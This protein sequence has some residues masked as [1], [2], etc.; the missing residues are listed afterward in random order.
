MALG[1]LLPP[2]AGAAASEPPQCHEFGRTAVEPT[3]APRAEVRWTCSDRASQPLGAAAA[4][5]SAAAADEPPACF[6]SLPGPPPGTDGRWTVEAG[7]VSTGSVW[8]S[9]P[10]SADLAFSVLDQPDHGHVGSLQKLGGQGATF[11]YTADAGHRGPDAFTIRVGDGANTTDTLVLVTVVEPVNDPPTCFGSILAGPPGPGGPYAVEAG[12]PARG[13]VS[14]SDD[15]R[16]NLSFSIL[17]G[18]DHGTL[19]PPQAGPLIDM[20]QSATFTYTAAADYRGPDAFTFRVSDGTHSVD[21]TVEVVVGD[22]VDTPPSCG[23]SLNGIV[24]AGGRFAVEDGDTAAGSIG[25]LDDGNADLTFTVV[26]GPDHGTMSPLQEQQPFPG[27]T[28]Q[29]A[30]YTYKPVAG[31]RGP[32]ALTLRV[33]DGATSTDTVVLISVVEPVDDPPV[34]SATLSNTG[35]LLG[36]RLPA[37]AGEP[38]PGTLYCT[39]DEGD[40]LTFSIADGP[41]HGTLSPLQELPLGLG[42]A[43]S[44]TYTPTAAHRGEDEFTVRA[45]DGTHQVQTVLA[46]TVVEPVNDAPQCSV[47]LFPSVPGPAGPYV[48]EAGEVQSGSVLCTDDEGANLAFSVHD[49]PDHGTLGPLQTFPP[50]TG[51]QQA[52]FTYTPDLAYRGADE[53]T[54]RVTDGQNT[55]DRKLDV[56]VVEP[57]NQP[58]QC[59]VPGTITLEQGEKLSFGPWTACTD[60]DGDTLTLQITDQ[61]DHG[62]ITG[63]DEDGLFT[64]T[65][66]PSPYTGPDSFGVSVSDGVN[67][68]SANVSIQV[69]EFVNDTP[70]C[71]DDFVDVRQP[72]SVVI[73]P[74]CF[75]DEE[76][77]LSYAVSRA[78]EHG[79]LTGDPAGGGWTYTPDPGYTG[80]DS[81][82]YRAN[83]GTTDS[84]G[85][86]VHINVLPAHRIVLTPAEDTPEVGSSHAVTA[87]VRDGSG[88]AQAGKHVRW[89]IAGA[90]AEITGGGLT[91]AFGQVEI[92]W[93]RS[94]AGNDEL[95]AYVD[96]DGDGVQDPGE[97]DALARAHWRAQSDV[98][99]PDA[100]TPTT[101]TGAPLPTVDVGEIVNPADPGERYFTVS[102]S[103]T[104]AAGVGQCPGVADGRALKLP[105]SVVIDPGAGAVQAGSVELFQ[106]AAGAGGSPL[107]PPGVMEPTASTGGK[108]TF[109]LDCI[110]TGDLYLRYTL[111]EG[112][113]SATYTVPIGGIVLIDPQ[114][115]V[116][117]A[118]AYDA[119]IAAGDTPEQAR[120]AAAIEG[121]TVTLQRKVGDDFVTVLS[122]D[123]GITPHVNPQTIGADGRYQWDV[124][125]GV[126]RVIVT[127]DGYATATSDAVTIPPPVLDLH[128]A[129]EPVSVPDT[130]APET[131][132]TD[133]PSG[134]TSDDTPTFAFSS[135][136]AGSSFECRVDGAAFAP[137]SS[138]YTAAALAA[139]P[140]TF[141]VRAR[142]AAGNEDASPARRSFTVATTTGGGT[143]TAGPPVPC[144]GKTGTALAKCR[145]DLKVAKTCGSLKGKKK[146]LCAKRVRAIDK[147]NGL[148]AKTKSQKAKKKTCLRKAKKIGRK[149]I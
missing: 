102:R 106:T 137:C 34:C 55:V 51:F 37:E 65:A 82:L 148:K 131:T 99:P 8:C 112:G 139:G 88:A 47:F 113:D 54:L 94:A 22:P 6:G 63:P 41:D 7:D 52:S 120:A 31:Y 28:T 38:A 74:G 96:E 105:I 48:V 145:L 83:D 56:S 98:E 87:T 135:S 126:Y 40:D 59:T 36:G 27:T 5:R 30:T 2:S 146:T 19:T 1:L 45:S 12:E 35:P 109:V 64:Y 3:L 81:F 78:P 142:D 117:D 53:F 79:T 133:G 123:P 23:V 17:D 57:V 33:S 119:R 127:K 70:D 91:N 134:V 62:T 121:A 58:P 136:E 69:I 44:F 138:P 21:T 129:L 76:Q 60:P 18:P 10:D 46:I 100:G 20:Y 93:S 111:T 85:A 32:D 143:T 125:A 108:Y 75:D 66:P 13:A 39:D 71:F 104:A 68:L 107:T 95:E 24:P 124:S 97:S 110:R 26:D 141:D 128:V 89:S 25:C 14:C 140:H 92:A 72:H 103:Q 101:P 149:P 67:T 42:E 122:G 50:T 114:G 61:P 4:G 77:A 9:D 15:E 116:Y 115:V 29:G 118:H 11:T 16:A 73:A 86:T 80:T 147:C 43:A 130:T 90:G 49:G 84:A 132:I 144:Q